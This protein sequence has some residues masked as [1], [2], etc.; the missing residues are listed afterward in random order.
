MARAMR[1]SALL[2]GSGPRSEPGSFGHSGSH[3]ASKRCLRRRPGNRATRSRA[4]PGYS[5]F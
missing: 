2:L 1:L 5:I 4:H 3:R